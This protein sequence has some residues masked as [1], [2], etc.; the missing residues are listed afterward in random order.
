M[1]TL[2]DRLS[3]TRPMKGL[4]L[5]GVSRLA[6][7]A[8]PSLVF[9]SQQQDA[10]PSSECKALAVLEEPTCTLREVGEMIRRA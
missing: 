10:A 9:Q 3:G 4:G 6:I 8:Q 7:L 2:A 5:I 1:N